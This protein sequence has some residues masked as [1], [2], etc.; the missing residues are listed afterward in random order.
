MILSQTKILNIFPSAIQLGNISK[1]LTNS[2]DRETLMY[3]PK[4]ELWINRL[5]FEIANRKDYSCLTI[6][7]GKG[8]PSKYRT[9]ADNNVRVTCFF[10]QKKK[11]RVFDR[12]TSHNLEL[13]NRDSLIF[14]IELS[15]KNSIKNC[16]ISLTTNYYQKVTVTYKSKMIT[17][18][19]TEEISKEKVQKMN[20]MLKDAVIQMEQ[21]P[22]KDHDFSIFE[23]ANQKQE[24]VMAKHLKRRIKPYTSSR[25]KTRN[26]FSNISYTGV[27]SKDFA[28]NNFTFDT[29]T[30]LTKN[31]NPF[32][33]ERKIVDAKNRDMI[34]MLWDECIEKTFY[35]HICENDNFIYLNGKNIF[36]S[37]TAQIV[38]D[39]LNKDASNI[40]RLRRCLQNH[41][42]IIKFVY[43]RYF[44]EIYSL[45]DKRGI[46]LK[47]E[48]LLTFKL[49]KDK[50]KFLT[51]STNEKKSEEDEK[52]IK[53]LQE[54]KMKRKA[55]AEKNTALKE[56]SKKRCKSLSETTEKELRERLD[57]LNNKFK[58]MKDLKKK[59]K[60]KNNLIV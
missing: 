15:D 54:K 1:I 33:L 18:V 26:F 28:D 39:Y 21:K 31:I 30:L 10:S 7:C 37:K 50:K 19:M 48:F 29:I 59:N 49:W 13:D 3:I 52:L 56:A 47:S 38:L 36:Y 51:I 35:K 27:K 9:E 20:Q 42:K 25:I 24:S 55:L 14:K 8:G 60:S 44:P 5:Y 6:D 57:T 45:I 12:F 2:C 4:R 53:Q 11:D 23:E 22:E 41:T 46:N 16:D 17:E 40:V 43:S 32:S 34:Y 58:V